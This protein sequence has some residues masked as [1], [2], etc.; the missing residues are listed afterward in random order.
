MRSLLLAVLLLFSA[1]CRA[2]DPIDNL[3]K[4]LDPYGL[5][6]NGAF[7][8]I[9][10]PVSASPRQVVAEYLSRDHFE[11]YSVVEIREIN[12]SS[13]KYFAALINSNMG[14]KIILFKYLGSS[15][16]TGWWARMYDAK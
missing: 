13:Y 3:L 5:W 15:T 7:Q 8:P 14:R 10:L 16:G 2:S 1:E 12:V 9:V 11:P 4:T 6:T